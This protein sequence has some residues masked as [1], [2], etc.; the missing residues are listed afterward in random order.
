M[1]KIFIAVLNMSL[2]ASFVI[3]AVVL[4]RLCLRRAPKAFSYALWAVVLFNLVCPYKF[5]SPASLLPPDIPAVSAPQSQDTAYFPTQDSLNFGETAITS[6]HE[7]LLRKVVWNERDTLAVIWLSGIVGM[8]IY[9]VITYVLLKRKLRF[10][11][12]MD[13]NV[14][15]TDRILRSPF[16]LGFVRP[17]IYVPVGLS[18]CDLDYILR[19]E[20]T[21]IKRLD[22]IVK[23]V[24]F[25]ALALH[26][27]NPLV[28]LAYFLLTTDMEMSCDERVLKEMGGEVKE[29]Y[30][31]ALLSLAT[32]RHLIGLSPLAF[33]EGNTKKRIKNVLKFK[34]PSRIIIA[35]A[36]ILVVTLTAGFAV[37]RAENDTDN[38]GFLD[39]PE[40][41]VNDATAAAN[42]SADNP[43]ISLYESVTDVGLDQLIP[44][45]TGRIIIPD[46]LYIFIE[47]PNDTGYCTLYY[48]ENNEISETHTLK[49]Y[50][51]SA[52]STSD[53]S[54]RMYFW[55]VTEEYPD[56]FDG[57]I[58]AV[59][60]SADGTELISE[61]IS[62]CTNM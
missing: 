3:V 44:D 21:H 36:M 34:K 54:V 19:H 7:D 46:S 28:W 33:G 18:D 24:A 50:R 42:P 5:E 61:K 41:P 39:E 10:A 55:N 58:W 49:D 13:G 32:G 30:S 48:T 27:F 43:V 29:A 17:K 26:W 53:K 62:I 9:T 2:T 22:Y 23:P 59:A 4:A 56:G 45:K 37:N 12:K 8:L 40:T 51:S 35:A 16:V 15:E 25:L 52:I 11:T 1:D 6:R 60:N 47:M 57:Q 31:N 38:L 14:Y 20:R